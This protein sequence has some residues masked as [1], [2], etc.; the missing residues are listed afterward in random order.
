M[1]FATYDFMG[2]P[3]SFYFVD[4]EDVSGVGVQ[5]VREP[6]HLIFICDA[7]G[8]MWGQMEGVRSLLTK[9]LTLEEYRD[10]N[11]LISVL[12][13]SSSGDLVTH[14]SRVAVG[15]FMTPN[16]KH[17]AQVQRLTTRGLTCISQGLRAVPD[18]VKTETT[19][20]VLLSD[21]FAND[22]SPGAEKREIDFLVEKLRTLPNVFVNTISLGSWADFGLLSYIANACSGTCFQAPSAREVYDVLHETTTLISGNSSPVITVPLNGASYATFVSRAANKIVGG[23]SDL[24]I[25]GLPGVG[26]KTI[27]RYFKVEEAEWS[28]SDRPVADSSAILA[29]ARSSLA[30]GYANRAK[31]AVMSTRDMTLMGRHAK[32]LVNSELA[33][34]ASDLETAI[35]MGVEGHTFSETFGLPNARTMS[36]LGVLSILSQ[37]A[38]D[39]QVDV[40]ALRAGYQKRSVKRVAGT[41]LPDGTIQAPWVKTAFRKNADWA[42]VNSFDI[43]RANASINMLISRPIDLVNAADGTVIDSVAGIDLDLKAHNNYTI[44]GDGSLTVR[45]LVVRIGN[46]RLFNALVA[47]KV[48]EGTFSPTATYTISFEDRPLIAYDAT[49]EQSLFDGQFDRIA[50]LKVIE[51]ILNACLKGQSDTLTA[52]QVAEL[53][54]FHLT[55]SLNYSPP[56]T[57]EY[58]DLQQALVDGII[59]TRLTYKIDFGSTEIPNL[60]DLYSANEYLARRFTM[61]AEGSEIKK[62]TFEQRW[63][64]TYGIKALSARTS[65]NAVDTLMFP[66]FQEFLG[67][68]STGPIASILADLEDGTSLS[69]RLRDAIEGSL[70]RDAVVEVF[71]DVRRAVSTEIEKTFAER[72]SPLVF[73]VGATGLFP[74]EF[75]AVAL[76]AEQVV[77]KHPTLGLGKPEKTENNLYYIVGQTLVTVAIGT[78]YFS[79]GKVVSGLEEAD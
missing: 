41:R 46:K 28:S 15:E 67:F 64:A 4:V 43:N 72:I 24:L 35:L 53:K 39:V 76:T 56:T 60:G 27:Y 32:A 57:T 12:S 59:D 65:L 79:T 10:T 50:R 38:S 47:A 37:Y 51:S 21:G 30:E 52:E 68:T 29:F 25:R 17:L 36:V 44:V 5:T 33:A 9:L 7:S 71:T 54:R 20:V 61:T 55:T 49:F 23:G 1:R 74:D 8:S 75:G 2:N 13:F 18:L 34:F 63:G 42:K 48:L 77:A 16:S 40:E 6:G 69:A 14:T 19:G 22:R 31:F 66:I 70:S 78:A 73:Y 62:P 3:K 45:N 26:D 11:T 58:A